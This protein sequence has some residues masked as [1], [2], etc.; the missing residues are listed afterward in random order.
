MEI[1]QKEVEVA[2]RIVATA[3]TKY[4]DKVRLLAKI[5]AYVPDPRDDGPFCDEPLV[6]SRFKKHVGNMLQWMW[7]KSWEKRDELEAEGVKIDNCKY[8]AGGWS[9]HVKYLDFYEDGTIAGIRDNWP[10]TWGASYGDPVAK[11]PDRPVRLAGE[12]SQEVMDKVIDILK[13]LDR[14][15]D[16]AARYMNV[17]KVVKTAEL[18]DSRERVKKSLHQLELLEKL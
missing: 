14:Y 1:T 6:A 9:M 18:A 13:T 2:D 15:I 8:D 7:Q 11:I 5:T 10:L 16:L 17:R 4:C 12:N 3:R